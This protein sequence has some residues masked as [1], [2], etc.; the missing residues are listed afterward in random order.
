MMLISLKIKKAI[1]QEI[2]AQKSVV[3]I[4]KNQE[5]NYGTNVKEVVDQANNSIT[6][7]EKVLKDAA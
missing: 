4:L 1:E 5:T 2:K 7:Y 3:K 6:Y